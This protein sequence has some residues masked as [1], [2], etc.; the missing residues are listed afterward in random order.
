MSAD[1]NQ[2][3]AIDESRRR[4]FE[5]AR[6]NGEAEALDTFLPHDTDPRYLPTME[7]LVLID[8]EFGWRSFREDIAGETTVEKSADGSKPLVETYLKRF[9]AL[10][11]PEIVRR[12]LQQEYFVRKKFGDRPSAEEYR[13]RFPEVIHDSQEL[14][15]HVQ[16]LLDSWNETAGDSFA[17]GGRVDRYELSREHGRG[18]FGL[19]WQADD[20]KLGRQVALK[21]LNSQLAQQADFRRRFITEARIAAKLEHPGIV[22]VYDMGNVGSETPY[23]TMKMVGGETLFEAI[24]N[25]HD[26][27]KK[28]S[29]RAVEQTR[30]LSVFL[31]VTRTME[32]AHT[33]HVIHRDLK[34]QNII[35][36][37]FGETIILDWGLA[38]ELEVDDSP[39]D[40][41][42]G[43]VLA[44]DALT[45]QP[46]TI[47]GTPH[48]MSPEQARGNIQDVD[49]RSDIYSLG[50]ILYQILTGKFPFEGKSTHEVLDRVRNE[51]PP[52][53]RAVDP[54]IPK[55]LE[56][57][58]LKAMAKHRS[59]RYAEIAPLRKD[60]ERYL[61]DEPVSV[62][63]ESPLQRAAR[64]CRQHKT[65]VT[66]GVVAALILLAAGVAGFV[67]NERNLRREEQ[68]AAKIE[69]QQSE[70]E[71]Q[72]AERISGLRLAAEVYQQSAL[73]KLQAGD[74]TAAA[75]IFDDTIANLPSEPELASL[76]RTLLAQQQRTHK[77]VEFRESSSRIWFTA[78]EERHD[79]AVRISKSTIAELGIDNQEKWWEH[80]PTADL[81]TAQQDSIAAEVHQLMLLHAAL[82]AKDVL[83][84]FYNPDGKAKCEE[85]LDVLARTQPYENTNFSRLVENFCYLR[86][87]QLSKYKPL[88]KVEPESASD[89]LLFGIVYWQIAQNPES[90]AASIVL[91]LVKSLPGSLDTRDPWHKAFKCV[92]TAA[93]VQ[94]DRYWNHFVLGWLLIDAGDYFHGEIALNACLA[95]NPNEPHL[96]MARGK[97]LCMQGKILND[98]KIVEQGDAEFKRAL[99]LSPAD[100]FILNEYA[101]T[102]FQLGKFEAGAVHL[103]HWRELQQDLVLEDKVLLEAYENSYPKL[104]GQNVASKEYWAVSFL[105]TSNYERAEQEANDLLELDKNNGVAL[106]VLGSCK[107]QRGEMAEALADFD[108]ALEVKPNYYLAVF[109]RA[110]CLEQQH[111]AE[112]ALVAYQHATL[113]AEV[114]WQRKNA[115]EG[116]IRLLEKMNQPKA[117]ATAKAALAQAVADIAAGFP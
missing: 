82:L 49:Q 30:L 8:L 58:C 91:Q 2:Q 99:A 41:T 52:T 115:L 74:F 59:A 83:L 55:P 67:Q 45:T 103:L 70:M 88:D 57:I 102:L 87:G 48:Y 31:A 104:K 105:K 36:G 84:D 13:R 27:D 40:T 24:R 10:N 92:Q 80:L 28:S 43:A 94:P 60:L 9:P 89:Y 20:R 46:G 69:K 111:A 17:E 93:E 97:A 3:S 71:R 114:N 6:I 4:K 5:V 18:G 79:E 34:P 12:L 61:A 77:L 42:V 22:P 39:L 81:T 75:T 68:N 95:L 98:E 19:V 90:D 33:H 108:A 16:G 38:K 116:E 56:A 65:T 85:A 117:L 64:W 44:D 25:F 50:V 1:P 109:R 14:E 11:Q 112:K 62:C 110:T 54:R 15:S 86:L 73:A 32:Y 101:G 35:L 63:P 47:H 106:A 76:R 100:M 23:Y 26:L 107:L 78:G 29:A 53:P 66:T 37:D 51:T 113:A 7:E 72:H 96:H 21:Q